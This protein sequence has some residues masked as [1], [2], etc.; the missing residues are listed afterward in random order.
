MRL[1]VGLLLAA[2]LVLAPRVS[3]DEPVETEFRGSLKEDA[4]WRGTVRLTGDVTVEEG[5]RLVIERGT[6]VVI[7]SRADPRGGW[8]DGLVEIHVRGLL[9]ADGELGQPVEFVPQVWLANPPKERPRRELMPWL[10]IV[11][12]PEAKPHAELKGCVFQGALE[13]VQVGSSDLR[14]RDCVF[15]RCSTGV[16]TGILWAAPDKMG[17]EVDAGTCVLDDCRFGE[18]FAGVTVEADGRPE[19]ERCLFFGCVFGVANRR[20]GITWSARSLGPFADRSLFLRCGVGLQ[21]A[22]RI[23]NSMFVQNRLA[24]QASTFQQRYSSVTDRVVRS[25]NLYWENE[26]LALG[27]TPA[28]DAVL[29]RDPEFVRE[30]PVTPDVPTLSA[31]LRALFQLRPTSPALGS[32]SDG[33]DR[34]IAGQIGTLRPWEILA[35]RDE[36]FVLGR[37]LVAGP[38]SA[39]DVDL[40]GK[41][42]RKLDGHPP[43]PGQSFGDGSWAVLDSAGEGS[44]EASP[45]MA[46]GRSARRVAVAL[47]RAEREVEA[48]LL[49]GLDGMARAWW[50]GRPLGLPTGVRRFDPEDGRVPVTLAAG[51]NVLVLDLARHGGRNRF[52]CRLVSKDDPTRAPPGVSREDDAYLGKEADVL[53]VELARARVDPG[54]SPPTYSLGLRLSERVHWADVVVPGR[55]LEVVSAAGT[56]V[57]LGEAEVD[58]KPALRYLRLQGLALRDGVT[59]VVRLRGARAPDGRTLAVSGRPVEIEMR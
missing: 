31:N 13:A 33:G 56:P 4:T 47:C 29:L 24:L 7:S 35:R 49:L 28:G 34:G 57:D 18:C 40:D 21:G 36:A 20:D 53:G 26:Q 44:G 2:L 6:R 10:G 17:R 39:V 23:T 19:I 42:V 32:A 38:P 12:H 27:D 14:L 25:H 58:Y 50:N 16:Q 59:Y 15:H 3:A 48:T 37:W 30:L 52:L 45:L 11:F 51:R 22:S 8:N 41:Q 9:L 1:R 46:E 55:M 43:Q 5:V 54:S